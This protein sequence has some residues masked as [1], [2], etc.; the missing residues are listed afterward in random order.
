MIGNEFVLSRFNTPMKQGPIDAG[1]KVFPMLQLLC[2]K[3]DQD[4]R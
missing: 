4:L 3:F 2:G 1:W